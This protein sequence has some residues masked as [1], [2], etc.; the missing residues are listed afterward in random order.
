MKTKVL[1]LFFLL[2]PGYFALLS[3]QTQTMVERNSAS[4]YSI[5]DEFTQH[6]LDT[7]LLHCIEVENPGTYGETICLRIYEDKWEAELDRISQ[8]L[9][10][11]KN[12]NARKKWQ[13]TQKHWNKFK[14]AEFA[15]IE[16]NYKEDE[17][18]MYARMAAFER[19]MLVRH[20]ALE[21]TVYEA[22]RE[23]E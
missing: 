16:E 18:T 19:L 15:F 2:F 21:L 17:G 10:S 6:P 22:R 5:W 3:A 8:L 12:E 13:K 11:S 20:R 4:D 1:S 9:A 23:R 14:A 7:G